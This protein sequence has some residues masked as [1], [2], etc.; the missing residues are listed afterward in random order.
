[1]G[2]QKILYVDDDPIHIS[3]MCGLMRNSNF[4]IIPANSAKDAISILK[5]DLELKIVISD[6]VMPEMDGLELVQHINDKYPDKICYMLS[7]SDEIDK[8][9]YF[10]EKGIIRRYFRKP[11]NKTLLMSDLCELLRFS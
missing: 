6:W 3:L 5:E 9:K 8:L 10:E 1:M 2:K 4:E 11:I 7:S